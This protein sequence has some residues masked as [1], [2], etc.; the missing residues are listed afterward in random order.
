MPFALKGVQ[1]KVQGV[2]RFGV[3][4]PEKEFQFH[5]GALL[6]GLRLQLLQQSIDRNGQ[7]QLCVFA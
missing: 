2:G 4:Q 1:F 6:A 7:L 3:R 5:N